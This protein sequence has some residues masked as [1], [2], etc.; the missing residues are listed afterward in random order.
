M[1]Q[2]LI[3]T[4]TFTDKATQADR[5]YNRYYRTGQLINAYGGLTHIIEAGTEQGTMT[6][7]AYC[8]KDDNHF[9]VTIVEKDEDGE[10]ETSCTSVVENG[11]I[12]SSTFDT[13][14]ATF[15]YED[16]YLKSISS[17]EGDLMF[18]RE[19]HNYYWSEGN[20]DSIVILRNDEEFSVISFE[21][22]TRK[23]ENFV[24]NIEL[25]NALHAWS[26]KHM[27]FF[28]AVNGLLGKMP[29]NVCVKMTERNLND[30]RTVIFA[31]HE[32]N[33]QGHLVGFERNS[34]SIEDD[35]KEI[36]NT[37]VKLTYHGPISSVGSMQLRRS[38]PTYYDLYGRR[39]NAQSQ[40]LVIV[41]EADGTT[42]KT[43]R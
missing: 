34:T 18:D 31:E 32:V 19:Q 38:A 11:H 7:T 16:G 26:E 25:M 1:A 27:N 35:N 30:K 13:N 40:G 17:Q 3:L 5:G 6:D 2:S 8:R 43:L 37:M 15:E 28:A 22:S 14:K 36:S 41:R 33:E 24:F 21:Y 9:M 20:L 39:A 42:H 23:A 4:R 29:Q 10:V 12:V